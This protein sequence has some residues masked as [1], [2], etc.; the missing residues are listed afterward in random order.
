MKYQNK[1]LTWVG[2]FFFTF[3]ASASQE[4]IDAVKQAMEAGF[5]RIQQS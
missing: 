5:Q 1:I 3:S 2:L 4:E